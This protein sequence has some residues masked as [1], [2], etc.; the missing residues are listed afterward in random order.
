MAIIYFF[1]VSFQSLII[2]YLYIIPNFKIYNSSLYKNYKV[3][4]HFLG[5]TVILL[6]QPAW[7]KYNAAQNLF[8]TFGRKIKINRNINWTQKL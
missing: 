8:S 4:E 1:I 5:C 6:K 3:R 2:S 7:K